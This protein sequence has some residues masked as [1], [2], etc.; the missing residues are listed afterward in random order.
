ME[1]DCISVI[2]DPIL[3]V[4][5]PRLLNFLYPGHIFVLTSLAPIDVFSS[6]L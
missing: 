6:N 2:S 5:S 4:I 1:L 3:K